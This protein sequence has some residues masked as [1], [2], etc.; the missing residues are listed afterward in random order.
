MKRKEFIQNSSLLIAGSL[1][2]RDKL[3][4]IVDGEIVYG[5]NEKK[6]KLVKDWVKAD[7]ATLPVNDCHEM[8][9]DAKGRIVLLTNETKK[10]LPLSGSFYLMKNRI[11]IL[12]FF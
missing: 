10:L 2:S 8:V 9:Q 1:I 3:F 12:A 6:Y 4:E 5:Q 7:A 11:N